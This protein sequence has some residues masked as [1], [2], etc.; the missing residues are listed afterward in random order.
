MSEKQRQEMKRATRE[1]MRQPLDVQKNEY[2]T[3]LRSRGI[4]PRVFG[5]P[6]AAHETVD[7]TELEK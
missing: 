4:T 6:W 3:K 2:G 1:L 7:V 5:K